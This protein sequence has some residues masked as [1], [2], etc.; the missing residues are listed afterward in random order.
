VPGVFAVGNGS[1]SEWSDNAAFWVFN[2]LS[3][4]AYTRYD[5]IHPYIEEAQKNYEDKYVEYVAVVDNAAHQLYKEDK[6]KAE[7]FVT[8]FSV[9]TANNLVDEWKELYQFLFMKFMD[10]NI[11]KTEGREFLDNGYD[12]LEIKQPG[13]SEEFYKKIIEQTGE[14]FKVPEKE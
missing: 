10:G 1:M 4:F 7:D 5:D 2:Q 12:V 14:K 9:N 3:N 11:K 13:Y 6:K 8:E